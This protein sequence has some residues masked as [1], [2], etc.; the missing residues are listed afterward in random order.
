MQLQDCEKSG[1]ALQQRI[2]DVEPKPKMAWKSAQG[3]E[4][5]MNK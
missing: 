4:H 3:T 2:Q 1:S 5:T